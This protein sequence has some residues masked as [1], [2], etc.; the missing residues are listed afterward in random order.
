MTDVTAERLIAALAEDGEDAGITI[1]TEWEPIG[2]Q[3]A[4]V[5]PAI[6]AGGKY[7]F[8]ERWWGPSAN[9]V[10]T[11]TVS[12]D[13]V[14]SQ[15]NRLEAAL[16]RHREELGLP[17]L[18]LDLSSITSLPVHL[19]KAI[20]SFDLPHRNADAYLRDALLDGTDFMKSA[21]GAAVFGSSQDDPAGLLQWM[22]QA[23]LY[24]FWQS[25]L[26]K[27]R[28]QTK[29]ARVWT[30]EMFGVDPAADPAALTRTLGTKG[31]PLNLSVDSAIEFDE[32]D[33][34]SWTIA[35]GR[36]KKGGAKQSEALSNLGHGQVPFDDGAPPVAVSCRE[37]HQLSTLSFAGLRRLKASAEA[38]ALVASIG[39]AAH[40][41]AFHRAVHL[42]SGCDLRPVRTQWTWLGGDLDVEVDAPPAAQS[43]EL[44]R[45]LADASGVGSGW[46]APVTLQPKKE[47]VKVIVATWPLEQ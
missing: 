22:P 27:K 3:G 38:R 21:I 15:A 42:R 30:S 8:G 39:L 11:R 40:Q 14:P 4:P 43:V 1:T 33:Q 32:N 16:K 9:R 24:G 28:Q 6:Y 47:L 20:S 31:D 12:L 37:I 44:V 18:V 19:P 46:T 26:G 36:A 45:A 23:F 41:L 2:G 7:Q 35:D 29:W 10:R 17:E 13:S 5:K 25:H 34:Q